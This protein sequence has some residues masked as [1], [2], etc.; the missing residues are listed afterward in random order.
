MGVQTINTTIQINL[1]PPAER[2]T[3]WPINGLFVATAFIMFIFFAIF[4]GLN[5]YSIYMIENNLASAQQQLELLKPTQEKMVSFNL[6]QQEINAKTTLLTKLTTERRPWYTIV[7]KLAI[8][9]PPQIWLDEISSSDKNSFKIK[10][11]ALTY[12]DLANFMQRVEQ[13]E[14]FSEPVLIRAERDNQ[15]AI[16][17]FEMTIKIEGL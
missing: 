8:I 15:S 14:M 6:Q 17:R 4:A 12:P 16:T 7:S 5:A 3:R 9:V 2:Q 10:A 1:L 11:N 13:D